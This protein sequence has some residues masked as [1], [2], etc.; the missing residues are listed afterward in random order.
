M[1]HIL[2]LLFDQIQLW[3]EGHL[4]QNKCVPYNGTQFVFDIS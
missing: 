3:I 1:E 2:E 4:F